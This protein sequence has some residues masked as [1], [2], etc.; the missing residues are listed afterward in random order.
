[1]KKFIPFILAIGVIST[2]AA[3]NNSTAPTVDTGA[4]TFTLL[5]KSQTLYVGEDIACFKNFE[6]THTY[7][8]YLT[9]TKEI[10]YELHRS[11]FYPS[12]SAY[13]EFDNYY[14]YWTS[15]KSVEEEYLGVQTVK[16][17]TNYSYLS[18]GAD[19]DS[20]V[21]KTKTVTETSYDYTGGYMNYTRIVNVNLNGYFIST[22]DMASLCP[23]IA[24]LIDRSTSEK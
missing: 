6:T 18:R 13:V 23:D 10:N 21:V 16:I 12:S 17:T 2:F 14:Y 8:Q 11:A 7:P 1:M 24:K 22:F 15:T 5:E 20:L 19:S 3:C 9:Y 4:N